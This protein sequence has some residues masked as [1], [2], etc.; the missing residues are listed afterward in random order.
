MNYTIFDTFIIII[1]LGLTVYLG[2]RAKKYIENSE[3]Y[4]VAGRKVKLALGIATLVATEI[5]TVTFM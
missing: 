2:L 4:F 3:G 1:Y 5:G